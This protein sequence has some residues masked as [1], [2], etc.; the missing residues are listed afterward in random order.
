MNST[1]NSQLKKMLKGNG[2]SK[3]I[4]STNTLQV[5]ENSYFE[6]LVEKI[7]HCYSG[8]SQSIKTDSIRRSLPMLKTIKIN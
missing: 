8:P 3:I 6:Y 1:S 2:I 7:M 5:K 4:V